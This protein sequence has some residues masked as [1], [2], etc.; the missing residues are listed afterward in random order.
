MLTSDRTDAVPATTLLVKPPATTRSSRPLPTHV[1]EPWPL[2]HGAVP[3]AQPP[4][5]GRVRLERS[6]PVSGH[7][8]RR[9]TPGQSRD[10]P[11]ASTE[12]QTAAHSSPP[13]HGFSDS[14]DSA[15]RSDARPGS[16][17]LLVHHCQHMVRRR[18][19]SYHALC[20]AGLVSAGLPRTA[21]VDLSSSRSLHRRA[22]RWAFGSAT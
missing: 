12:I 3:M 19:R 10:H 4:C 15:P 6:L 20:T 21:R 9:P 22:A 2:T 8:S 16:Y 7:R 17:D 18:L 5:N 1:T 13:P 11:T 14:S